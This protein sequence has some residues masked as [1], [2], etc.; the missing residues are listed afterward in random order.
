[1]KDNVSKNLKINIGPYCSNTCG[2]RTARLAYQACLAKSVCIGGAR[3]LERV[4]GRG[5]SRGVRSL[6]SGAGW[7]RTSRGGGAPGGGRARGRA[8]YHCCAFRVRVVEESL[9]V[10]GFFEAFGRLVSGA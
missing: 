9:T 1:M 2:G 10:L 4:R 8:R 6:V 7:T 5:V 3:A